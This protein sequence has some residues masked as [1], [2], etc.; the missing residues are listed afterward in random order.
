MFDCLADKVSKNRRSPQVT[1]NQ[2]NSEPVPKK[3][4]LLGD[5]S[6][7]ILSGTR[8][9]SWDAELGTDQWELLGT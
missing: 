4:R 8:N 3:T 1:N 9:W 5:R 6:H 7:I 2:V